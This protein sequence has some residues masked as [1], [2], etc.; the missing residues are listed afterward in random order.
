MSFEFIV[1][2]SDEGTPLG[3]VVEE[4][5]GCSPDYRLFGGCDTAKLKFKKE[6][7]TSNV[8]TK[9]DFVTI[10]R[11]G[12]A[13]FSGRVE[14]C[15]PEFGKSVQSISV[16]GWWKRLK[17]REAVSPALLDHITFG[18]SVDSDHPD[19]VFAFDVMRWILDNRILNDPDAL[20]FEGT[21]QRPAYPCKLSGPFVLYAKDDLSKVIE[22]LATME[23]CV[24]G[25][26][27]EGRFY[28]FPR[29][30]AE[31]SVLTTVYAAK[32]VPLDWLS[33]NIAVAEGEGR[34]VY[35][36]RGPNSVAVYSRDK[37]D[38]P[39]IRSYHLKD[40][41]PEST[42]R[43]AGMRSANI[44]TGV[45]A[46][47]YARGIFRRFCDYS[48]KVE[49][50]SF[51]SAT[52]RFEPHLGRYRIEGPGATLFADKLAGQVS[53]EILRT[54]ISG[55]VTL[56]ENAA[57][58]TSGNPINDPDAKA[59][60]WDDDAQVNTGLGDGGDYPLPSAEIDFNDGWDGDGD[61][62]HQNP[63]RDFP[64]DLPGV[65]I[66]GVDYGS[67]IRNDANNPDGGNG[68][69]ATLLGVIAD[70][71]SHPT[72]SVQLYSADG[73]VGGE[74][75]DVEAWPVPAPRLQI[76][77]KVLVNRTDAENHWLD[78][79]IHGRGLKLR[80]KT[81]QP[82]NK[83]EIELLDQIDGTTVLAT[84]ANVEPW[85]AAASFA[86]GQLVFGYWFAGAIAP[87]PIGGSSCCGG[88]FQGY[89][90]LGFA[91]QTISD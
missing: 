26:D 13:I 85:P 56:G 33:Q 53:L 34:F 40:A 12:L 63:L 9:G 61:D 24:T 80:I 8:A 22:T 16:D 17:E 15:E 18:Q 5:L 76:G 51:R 39:S 1:Q 75:I 10:R 46:R 81:S 11:D 86:E 21:V 3:A 27:A 67:D 52:R 88:Y 50:L 25:I 32:E 23:D 49:Q 65:G 6:F 64:T 29:T 68:F 58:P 70:N 59:P 78:G 31:A 55:S 48:M 35:D 41:L 14:L 44:H 79:S 73:T 57:D 83:Y 66:P 42:K 91:G 84:F 38:D 69:G 36:R 28:Y 19:I 7:N 20:I 37:F 74:T 82:A 2:R 47:R 54:T 30:T 60:G 4:C 43:T 77:M 89:D 87:T 72:Y 45:Q 71:A 62:L 90:D